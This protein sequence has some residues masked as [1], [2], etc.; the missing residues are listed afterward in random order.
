MRRRILSG[1]GL[2]MALVAREAAATTYCYTGVAGFAACASATI[3]VNGGLTQL[4]VAIQNL[5]GNTGNT[6]FSITQFGLYY[7]V[8]PNYT[9]S[10]TSLAS[11]TGWRN[12]VTNSLT[13]PGPTSGTPVWIGGARTSNGNNYS[14][15]GCSVPSVPA[16]A[17]NTCSGPA[18]FTFTLA[19]GASFSLQNLNVGIRGQAWNATNG[20]FT[21]QSFKCYS[22]DPNCQPPLTSVPEPIS[23]A[24]MAT[25]LF[26]VGFVQLRRRRRR[27]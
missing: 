22:S 21:G 12:G 7:L 18:T 26:G 19:S 2:A 14:L 10:L 6:V 11:F 5:S 17:I 4:Q 13:N 1:A 16:N 25:G 15:V 20:A 24:L 27:E 8:P 3:V 9:G 23:M